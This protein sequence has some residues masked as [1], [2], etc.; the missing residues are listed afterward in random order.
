MNFIIRIL[1][2]ELK[3]SEEKFIGLL[4][5]KGL[6][7]VCSMICYPI[8]QSKHKKGEL[9]KDVDEELKVE[10]DWRV[11]LSKRGGVDE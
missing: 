10:K 5:E 9:D 1:R 6:Y 8:I 2:E 3:M 7:D 4:K 11:G